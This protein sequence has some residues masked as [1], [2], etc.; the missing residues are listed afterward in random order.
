LVAGL[1]IVSGYDKKLEA[2][3]IDLGFNTSSFE[4]SLIDKYQKA[5]QP[6]AAV[7]GAMNL[8]GYIDY[9]EK[10]ISSLTGDIV[11]FFH[12]DRC[13]TCRQAEDNFRAS[14]TPAG[15]TIV[16]V[17]YDKEIELKKKY[18][19]LT[20]T[21]FVYIKPDGTL[22]KRRVGGL[23]IQD[24][25][26]KITDAKANSG[27]NEP[28]RVASDQTAT[29]YFAGGCFRCMEGPLESLEGVREVINGY[30]GGTISDSTYEQVSRGTTANRESVK[31]LYDPALITYEE[32]L[33]TY[34]IQID[35]TDAGGQFA[36]RGN[37]YKTAIYYSN[38]EEKKIATLSKEKLNNSKK[39]DKPIVV[40]ILP[41]STFYKAEEYHQ[42][43]YKKH[44]AEYKSYKK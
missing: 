18:R 42:D 23:T 28:K 1:A 29:A 20:Q 38:D 4:Q 32:L 17:D 36:D 2:K 39:Y 13:P 26:D 41:A 19:I 30:I 5:D 40:D 7:S 3:L 9:D 33:S 16:K 22:I 25:L 8:S 44:S 35:P 24:M 21:S 12:A 15:L 10:I 11:L 6:V 27:S 37:Q 43:Y 31:V 14:G 34:R